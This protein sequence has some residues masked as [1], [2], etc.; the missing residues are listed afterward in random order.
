MS[1]INKYWLLVVGALLLASFI[2]G[3]AFLA[4]KLRQHQPWEIAISQSTIPEHAGQIYVDGAIACPGFYTFN[5]GDTLESIVLAAGVSPDADWNRVKL[6]IPR[7]G[8]VRQ[9]QKVNINLAEAWLISA[10]PGI[11]LETAQAIVDYRN[12]HGPFHRVEDLLRVRGIGKTTLNR[13]RGLVTL[14]E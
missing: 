10:L 4:M 9:A 6:Y 1:T 5:Q 8:E 11:G 2:A 13:I 14:E 12:Q 3:T 7:T